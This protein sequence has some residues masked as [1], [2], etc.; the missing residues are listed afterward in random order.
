[1][2][3]ANRPVSFGLIC[4]P[5]APPQRLPAVASACEVNGI[6]ELWLW[7][8]CFATSGLAPAVAALAQTQRLRV[9][10]GLMPVPLRNVA[11]TAME[12]AT[13]EGLYPGRLMPGIG[14]GV[15]DWMGQAGVRAESPLTLL[16][17]YATALRRLL[18]GE[19]VTTTGRYVT[20]RDVQLRWPPARRV[21]LFV[22]AEGP[23]TMAL[24]GEV[25]DGVIFTGGTSPTRVREGLAVAASARAAVGAASTPDAVVFLSVPV[26]SSAG[27]VA[28]LAARIGEAGSG[29]VAVC[30]LSD[31]GPPEGSERL[32]EFAGVV[33]EAARLLG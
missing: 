18:D 8:D 15:L 26:T 31:A 16:R 9:G 12:I 4:P 10:V 29:H 11:L 2:T 32:V 33:G 6:E 3:P 22:G 27:E 24:A 1:M 30:G 25:G 20:L 23:K 21:P 17:E 13:I 28:G 7:E 14:H 5:D 19:A